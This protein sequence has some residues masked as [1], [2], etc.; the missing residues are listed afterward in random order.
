[1][2]R[3]SLRSPSSVRLASLLAFAQI[4]DPSTE[5]TSS[6]PSPA[7]ASTNSTRVNRSSSG[8][9]GPATAVRNR[10]IVV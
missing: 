1:M 5:I 2:A 7:T 6:R 8:P 3:A 10:Q 9:P 4:F